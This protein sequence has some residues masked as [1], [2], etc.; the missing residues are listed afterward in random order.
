MAFKLDH[1]H[2]R[3]EDVTVTVDFYVKMFDAKVVRHFDGK[4]LSITWVQLSDVTLCLSP[5]PKNMENEV[6]A[7]P[8]TWGVYQIGLTVDNMEV[9]FKALKDKGA[10]F[11]GDPIKVDS[12]ITIAYMKAPDGV[13]IE[14]LEK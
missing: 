5:K 1:I 3:C 8:F 13:Q 9:T 2:F 10:E 12:G 7:D 14:L 4:F 11:E 6:T